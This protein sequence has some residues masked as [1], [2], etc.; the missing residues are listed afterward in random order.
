MVFTELPGLTRQ[1]LRWKPLP[2]GSI[3]GL[4]SNPW[5]PAGS[6]LLAISG[7]RASLYSL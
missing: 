7:E 3:D 5:A 2:K 1:V 6:Q 4:A